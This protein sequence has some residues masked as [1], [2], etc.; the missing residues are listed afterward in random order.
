MAFLTASTFDV[1]NDDLIDVMTSGIAWN[2]PENRTISWAV[3]DGLN[4]TWDDRSAAVDDFQR[5]LDSYEAFIDVDFAYIGEFSSPILA[6]EAGADIVYTL[7]LSPN[8]P[9]LF[10]SAY[11]PG[12]GVFN[13]FFNYATEDGDISLNF[14]NEIIATSSYEPGSD[15]FYTIIHELG[16]AMGLKH[17]FEQDLGRPSFKGIQRNDILDVEWF[18]IMSYTDPF[19]DELERW[20]PATPMLL[21]VLALQY[22][23]GPNTVTNAGNTIHVLKQVDYQYSVWDP[24]GVDTVDASGLSKGWR[25]ALPDYEDTPLVETRSGYALPQSE[26]GESLL[27]STPRELVWLVGDIEDVIGSAH[28]DVLFGTRLENRMSGGAGN[29]ELEGFEADDTL[30]GNGGDDIAFYSGFQDSYTISFSAD[31]SQIEDRRADGNGVDTLRSIETLVFYQGDD[32]ITFDLERFSGPTDLTESALESFIELYI[33]YFNRAPD[34]K[35]LWFW[36]SAFESGAVSL[37][38]A[39]AFFIDQDETRATYPS[40]LGNEAFAI[41]VYNNVLGREPDADGLSFWVE[42]LNGQQ[43][44]RDQF[45]REVL[46]GAKADPDPSLGQEFVDQQLADREYLATKTD[47]GALFAVHRG[48]SDVVNAGTAMSLYDGTH[49]GVEAA[50]AAIENYYAAAL[51]P[52]DGELL[53]PLVGVLD[54][55]FDLVV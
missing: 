51:D 49:S 45:I 46:K 6:G 48:M 7:S 20:D 14:A 41:L 21:D 31:G 44:P 5:A 29:D 33:A 16:H 35:G 36:G 11:Y 17:P 9:S 39:A 12:P 2:V 24:S 34:A 40:D 8:E 30:I 42:G 26:F 25:I 50:V 4:D 15:G 22:M 54:T 18:S 55:P 27:A 52:Y 13:V 1:T 3:A 19:E 38:Q 28:D 10:A 43:V 23:Y 37:E 32:S 47:I 53:L